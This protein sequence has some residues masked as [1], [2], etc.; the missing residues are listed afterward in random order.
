VTKRQH[1][2]RVLELSSVAEAVPAKRLL[3]GTYLPCFIS[4]NHPVAEEYK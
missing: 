4:Q 2:I 3:P 1:N